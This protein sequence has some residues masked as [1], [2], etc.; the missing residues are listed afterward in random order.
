LNININKLPNR[1]VSYA[2]KISKVLFLGKLFAKFAVQILY[3]NINWNPQV[4]DIGK[5]KEELIKI[6]E[7]LLK[8]RIDKLESKNC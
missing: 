6:T 8:D 1:W 7:V 4:V 2:F 3:N 5:E